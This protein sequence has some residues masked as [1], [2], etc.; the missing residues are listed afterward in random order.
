MM[1][2]NEWVHKQITGKS[3]EREW[4]ERNEGEREGERKEI[5]RREKSENIQTD[6][7]CHELC[8][9]RFPI[10][11]IGN[12][13]RGTEDCR[14]TMLSTKRRRIQSGTSHF[15]ALAFYLLLQL[16]RQD[17]NRRCST[18]HTENLSGISW[19]RYYY[20]INLSEDERRIYFYVFMLTFCLYC[21]C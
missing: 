16:I 8:R 4:M 9:F 21:Q 10:K 1:E 6:R 19:I 3:Q 20:R 15:T 13:L 18:W 2:L 17:C 14:Y 5:G 7:Y 12:D 11:G